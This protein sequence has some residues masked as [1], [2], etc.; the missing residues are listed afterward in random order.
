MVLSKKII[1]KVV[2]ILG[3]VMLGEKMLRYNS[4]LNTGTE[5]WKQ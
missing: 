5:I 3:T 1:R 4:M 2:R